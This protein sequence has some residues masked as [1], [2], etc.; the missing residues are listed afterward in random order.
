MHT[1]TTCDDTGGAPL[2]PGVRRWLESSFR[3]DLGDVR[4]H[5]GTTADA[6]TARCGALGVTR[7]TDVLLSGGLRRH[8]DRWA[9]VVAHEVAHTL[10]DPRTVGP[11]DERHAEALAHLAL[12]G[13]TLPHDTPPPRQGTPARAVRAFNAWEHRLLGDVGT[14]DLVTMASRRPGWRDVMARQLRYLLLWRSGP[15]SA[16]REQIH[17]VDPGLTVVTLG[18]G[19][20]ATLGELNAVGGDYAAD[21]TAIDRLDADL[22]GGFLQQVRQESAN[23][24]AALLGGVPVL[25]FNGAVTLYLGES[26]GGVLVETMELDR[27]TSTLGVNHYNGLLARNACHFAPF[28]WHRWRQ[29][30]TEARTLAA[31]SFATGDPHERGRLADLAWITQAYADH[32]VEDSFAAGH[33]TNKTLVMQWF[34]QWAA[35]QTLL[36]VPDWDLVRHMTPQEQPGL[37]ADDLYDVFAN[38]RSHDPQTVEEQ[39]TFRDRVAASQVRPGAVGVDVSYHQYLAFLDASVV[40]LSSNTVHNHYNEASLTVLST[41]RDG[42]FR[43]Y[44]DERLLHFGDAVARPSAAVHLSQ[45]AVRDILTTGHTATTPDDVL[46]RLPTAVVVDG[47]ARSLDRWHDDALR[48]FVQ[49]E[50]FS[51][52]VPWIKDA[53]A[54]MSPRMGQVSQDQRTSGL[55]T[56]WQT[57]LPDSGYADVW[58]LTDGGH[59]YASSH[60]HVY[61]LDAGTGQ[62]HAHNPLPGR[63]DHDVRIASNGA[64]VFAG[65]DGYVLGLAGDDLSTAWRTSL[66]GSGYGDTNV[67]VAQDGRLYAACRGHVY[68]LDPRTG[69]VLAH[70]G[71]SGRGNGEV[72]LAVTNGVLGAGTNGWVVGLDPGDLGTR[73]QTSL[74]GSGWDVVDVLAV[75][76]G[77]VV[78]SRGHVY[79]LAPGDGTVRAHNDLPGMGH[80]PVDVTSGGDGVVVGTA[81]HAIGLSLDGL[82]HRWT[83]DLSSATGKVVR[84]AWQKGWLFAAVNGYLY[85]LEP[86]TGAVRYTNDL[87]GRGFNDVALAGDGRTVFC[88]IH[89]YVVGVRPDPR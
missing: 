61:R 4:V 62:V 7:G 32:F 78:G 63:G 11:D 9:H 28:S 31:R 76:G 45:S 23:R 27:F 39:P 13:G 46:R 65:T 8:G 42:E 25:E 37:R 16:T 68:R 80:H 83:R 50:L 49:R 12:A 48:T 29:F 75:E 26:Q 51:G 30:H 73:W 6:V 58:P 47:Q 82:H 1:T 21:P 81:G 43:V 84:V 19:L 59:V 55:S 66:P 70:N 88:G 77:L 34:T 60:G 38:R 36:H 17:A 15:R 64:T 86:G 24:L 5:V 33:L 67:L 41:Q 3:T 72:R 52:W 85:Q 71:L 74:P 53:L 57:S 79:V 20:L 2:D 89:G 18:S 44:G 14:D 22:V 40:Q 56:A 10:Q 35:D 69:A 54:I 87:S